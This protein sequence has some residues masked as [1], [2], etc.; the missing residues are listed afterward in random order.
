VQRVLRA[1]G[2]RLRAEM[3]SV[4]REDCALRDLLAKLPEKRARVKALTDERDG[5]AKQVPP[6]GTLAE[7][8][9]RD[10]CRPS[11]PRSR[12]FSSELRQRSR[13]CSAWPTSGLD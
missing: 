1:E 10:D 6:A 2:E 7:K 8:K 9:L 13:I 5:L 3:R 11:A 12:R 4:I